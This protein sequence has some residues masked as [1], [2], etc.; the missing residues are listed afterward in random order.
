MNVEEKS[1][2][3]SEESL[4]FLTQDKYTMNNELDD[5]YKNLTSPVSNRIKNA[6]IYNTCMVFGYYYFSRNAVYFRNKKYKGLKDTSNL[7]ILRSTL[8][9]TFV[10]AVLLAPNLFILFGL[11]PMKYFREKKALEDQLLLSSELKD[12][13]FGLNKMYRK[14]IATTMTESE[15]KLLGKEKK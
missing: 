6:M 15:E 10:P 5:K 7:R 14:D 9:Y 8:F 4:A 2:L 11:H 3:I 1:R 13:L 12:S